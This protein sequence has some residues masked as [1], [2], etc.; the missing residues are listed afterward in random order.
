MKLYEPLRNTEE[1][2]ELNH[3]N[4]DINTFLDY[5]S[6]L[7][8]ITTESPRHEVKILL[9]NLITIA[10]DIKTILLERFFMEQDIEYLMSL[11]PEDKKKRLFKKVD[12]EDK[13]RLLEMD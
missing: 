11:L 4:K 12:K 2:P 7:G 8:K 10:E 13:F 9:N 5:L 1:Y 6:S 3:D